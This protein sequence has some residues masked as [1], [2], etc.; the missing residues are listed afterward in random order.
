MR[1]K[2]LFIKKQDAIIQTPRPEKIMSKANQ[3]CA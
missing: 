2:Q 1:F 3:F